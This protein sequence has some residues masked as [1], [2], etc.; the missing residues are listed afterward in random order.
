MNIDERLELKVQCCYQ[1]RSS[2][3]TL[4]GSFE[5]VNVF[6]RFCASQAN[7]CYTGE[8]E[9]KEE[10][11]NWNG[12]GLLCGKRNLTWN[13]TMI[14]RIVR[15]CYKMMFMLPSKF[16][17]FSTSHLVLLMLLLHEAFGIY[18]IRSNITNFFLK[19]TPPFVHLNNRLTSWINHS[20]SND[21]DAIYVT[22]FCNTRTCLHHHH[23]CNIQ[24]LKAIR[25]NLCELN[26][27]KWKKSYIFLSVLCFFSFYFRFVDF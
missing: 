21:G 1:H 19:H 12:S 27:R 24:W 13:F 6:Y 7:S 4:N 5:F 16:S 20:K 26:F 23:H 2:T 15:N 14:M 25:V 9:E 3:S 17:Q 8:K 22:S 18:V 10:G 11:K